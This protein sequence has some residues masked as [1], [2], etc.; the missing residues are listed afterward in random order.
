MKFL[1][2][3]FKRRKQNSI[4]K[5]IDRLQTEAMYLQ[6]NGKLR[7]YAEVMKEI[8]LLEKDL[9]HETQTG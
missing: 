7:H 6:R 5:K 4:I 3:F 8:E 9:E 1:T 2:D